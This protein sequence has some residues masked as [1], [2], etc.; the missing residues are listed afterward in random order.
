MYNSWIG[1]K[2]YEGLR[3]NTNHLWLIDKCACCTLITK[4]Y[5]YTRSIPSSLFHYGDLTLLEAILT[6]AAQLKSKS[7]FSVG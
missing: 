3:E 2:A 7:Y 4:S 5:V 6:M 1:I